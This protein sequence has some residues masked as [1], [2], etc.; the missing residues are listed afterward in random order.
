MVTALLINPDNLAITYRDQ[1]TVA[2]TL[3]Q[4]SADFA[5]R[6]SG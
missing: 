5:A 4:L 1:D 2:F 6:Q 3:M